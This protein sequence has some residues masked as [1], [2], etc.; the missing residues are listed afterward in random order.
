[1]Y[2]RFLTVL[3][4]VVMNALA[5]ATPAMAAATTGTNNILHSFVQSVH[6]SRGQFTQVQINQQGE[7]VGNQQSG[8]FSFKRPGLFKWHV[9]QPYEQLTL[10]DGQKLYQYDLDLAQVIIRNADES[11]GA[12]PA[13]FLFGAGDL[14]QSFA[15]EALP[16]NNGLEWLRAKPL[17]GEAGFLH[18]DIGFGNKLPAQILIT[19]SFGQVTRIELLNLT[20]NVQLDEGEFT[21]V[22]PADVDIV[23]M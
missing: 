5:A 8:D 19:D 12:S 1:M 23:N 20:T 14:D 16:D 22:P 10:S 18:M 11:L 15:I 21:F 7:P 6:S 3:F 17:E 9:T 2:I 4:A 13:A